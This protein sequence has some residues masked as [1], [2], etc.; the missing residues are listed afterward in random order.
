MLDEREV[1][2]A[3]LPETIRELYDEVS[4]QLSDSPTVADWCMKVLLL[5]R[6]SLLDVDYAASE[7]YVQQVDAKLKRNRRSMEAAGSGAMKLLWAWQFVMLLVCG[8]LVII[9]FIPALTLFGLPIASELIVLIRAVAWGGIGGVI[10][11]F[12]NMP[13]FTRH[14]EYDPAH[15]LSYFARPLQGMLLGAILF[16]ISQ[17]GILA[18]NVV[19]PPL[20][21]SNSPDSIALGPI[22]LYVFA[23]FAGFKEEYVFEFFDNILRAVFRMPR[24]PDELQIPTA[25]VKRR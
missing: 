24:V 3:Y 21:G 18:G 22:F 15:N 7:Y 19:I 12:Y 13:W 16:L 17:A 10:G 20:P 2:F 25:P 9:A 11:S 14:R 23:I 6:Q 4:T 1:Y 5:A 8:A